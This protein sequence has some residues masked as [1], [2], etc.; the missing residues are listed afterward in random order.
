M[1]VKMNYFWNL[2]KNIDIVLIILPVC[3][4]VFSITMIASTAYQ[5]RFVFSTDVRIQLA[6]YCLGFI[7][8]T[9]VLFIDYHFYIN[10]EKI[11]YVGSLIFLLSVY[12][13]FL[14]HVS[15]GG[16]RWINLGFT[17]L[18]KGT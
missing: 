6:A 13:P 3:F 2:L 10:M 7:A 9:V 11:L 12:V 16:A 5:G 4:S 18:R 15:D 14:R 8:M 17:C 1:K